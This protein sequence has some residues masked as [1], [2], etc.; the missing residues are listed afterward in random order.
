MNEEVFD[1]P[2]AAKYLGWENR[3]KLDPLTVSMSPPDATIALPILTSALAT[4]GPALLAKRKMP[5]FGLASR[6]MTIDG[7]TVPHERFEGVNEPT[8]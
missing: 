3:F 5:A 6:V 7:Q 8:V 4:T 2:A 1:L